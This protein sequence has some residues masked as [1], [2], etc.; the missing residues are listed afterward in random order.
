ME[1]IELLDVVK[2]ISDIETTHWDTGE[3]LTL[4]AGDTG[5]VVEVL[6]PQTYLV[7]FSDDDGEAYA[8]P[9]VHSYQLKPVW[10][11]KLSCVA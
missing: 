6:A 11:P 5:T 9:V 3:N 10:S 1:T 7:E 4:Q 8:L 2:L